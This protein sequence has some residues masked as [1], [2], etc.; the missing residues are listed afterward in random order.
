M[1]DLIRLLKNLVILIIIGGVGY[2]IYLYFFKES[3][4]DELRIDETP[5]H[6]EAIRSIAEISTVNYKDEVVMDSVVRHKGS[7]TWSWLD[8]Q[9]MVD[10][11]LNSNIKK[12]LTL[13][14]KGEVR[15]GVDLTDMNYNVRQTKDSIFI[16]LPPPKVLDVVVSPS[17]TEVFQEQGHWTDR[18]RKTMESKAKAKLISNAK[19]MDLNGKTER[20]MRTLMEQMI[21]TNKT[22]I[23][24]F[25]K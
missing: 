2:L 16:Q 5:I 21:Q 13:I 24:S 25:D 8:S 15:F 4:K 20:N 7:S 17:K 22:V 12:R 18:E 1:S 14:V 9:K 23:I 19:S 6:I 3:P 10:K 11:Y